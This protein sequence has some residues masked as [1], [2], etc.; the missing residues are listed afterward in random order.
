MESGGVVEE[1]PGFVTLYGDGTVERHEGN[2]PMRSLVPCS[3]EAFVDGVASNDVTIAE[4]TGLWA[5]IFCPEAKPAGGKPPVVLYFHGGGFCLGSPSSEIFHSLCSRMAAATGAVWVSVAYRLAPE[6][7]LPAACEDSVAALAWLEGGCACLASYGDLGQ[8]FLAG[9]SVGGNL[10]HHVAVSAAAR[11][12]EEPRRVRILGLVLLHPGFVKEERSRSETENPPE[13][14][15]VPV[16]AVD[17]GA[18]LALPAGSDKNHFAMNPRIPKRGDVALPPVL[19]VVGK[20]DIFYDR[21]VEYCR[22]ME[23]AG[24]E[25]EVVEYSEMGHCFMNEPQYEGCPEALDLVR[26]VVDFVKRCQVRA[27]SA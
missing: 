4:A 1:L 13:K 17:M 21:Q 14:A 19:V 11:K 23:G 5:R 8:C 7:R 12:G 15:L 18:K 26:K 20:M 27:V 6:H 24:H 25:V 9:D 10:A 3:P 2:D 22:A 16:E